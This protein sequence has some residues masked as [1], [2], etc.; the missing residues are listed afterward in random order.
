MHSIEAERN[1]IGSIFLD[2]GTLPIISGLVDADDFFD[3]KHKHIFG[4][5]S[6]LDK[7]DKLTD[8]VTVA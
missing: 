3:E 2:G 5:I 4:A 7:E 6:S 1:V 8:I